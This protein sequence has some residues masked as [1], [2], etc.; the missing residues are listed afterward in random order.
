M[1]KKRCHEN[2][3]LKL[4]VIFAL[5][6]LP[7]LSFAS[8]FLAVQDLPLQGKCTLTN[9]K[10]REIRKEIFAEVPPFS[11]EGSIEFTI[12][13]HDIDGIAMRITFDASHSRDVGTG[14]EKVTYIVRRI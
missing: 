4:V 1:K 11:D 10:T 5:A 8:D 9:L 14:Q 3:C 6:L 13:D 2:I 12:P 7:G